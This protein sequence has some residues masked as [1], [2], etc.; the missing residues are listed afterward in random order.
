MFAARMPG[1]WL[2]AVALAAASWS[3]TDTNNNAPV[4]AAGMGGGASGQDASVMVVDGGA[5]AAAETMSATEAA[6]LWYAGGALNAFT[7]SQTQTSNNAGPGYVVIPSYPTSSFRDLAFDTDGN[8][9]TVP[10]SGDRILRLPLADVGRAQAPAPTLVI[11]STALNGAESLVFDPAGNLWVMNYAG[12][13]ISTSTIVRFADPRKMSGDVT[14]TPSATIA[15]GSGD[16]AVTQLSQGTSIAFDAAGSLWFAGVSN[17]LRFDGAMSLTGNVTAA[18]SAV[19]S[20]G[21]AYASIVFDEAGSLWVTGASSGYFAMR[22]DQP[23]TLKGAVT[24]APAAKV[25]LPS[26]MT[27]LFASGMAFDAGGALWVAMSHQ[28]VQIAGAHALMGDVTPAPAVVLGIPGDPDLA[29]KIVVRPTPP[30][31]P[32]Y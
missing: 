27:T 5:D 25:H 11:T 2:G 21:E 17:V 24:A 8:L 31:L 3:C 12:A 23:G 7:K 30:D 15:P 29:S 19:I 32:I 6:Y 22:I 14:L 1:T 13:G 18:P 20:S 10:V 9:W 28:L 16:V 26:S 4:V